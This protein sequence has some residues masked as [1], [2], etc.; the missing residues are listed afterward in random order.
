MSM[1]LCVYTGEWEYVVY[2]IGVTP[3][4]ALAIQHCIVWVHHLKLHPMFVIDRWPLT[5]D[6]DVL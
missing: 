1:R 6:T 4:H 3:L 2:T 5:K